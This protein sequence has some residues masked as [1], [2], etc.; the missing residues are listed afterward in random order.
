[1]QGE[2]VVYDD[3]IYTVIHDYGN[4]QLEI[5]KENSI[6]YYGV[7]LVKIEEVHILEKSSPLK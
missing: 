6:Y 2:T 1:M 7:E 3:E 4:G 5:K